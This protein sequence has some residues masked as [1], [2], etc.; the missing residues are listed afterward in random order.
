MAKDLLVKPNEN[1]TLTAGQFQALAEVPAESEWF[2]SIA[3]PN[4]KRAYRADIGDFMQ[5]LGIQDASMLRLVKRAHVLAWRKTFDDRQLEPATVRRKIAAVSS[6]FNFLCDANAV[7]GNPADGVKRPNVGANE[8]KSPALADEQ[9]KQLLEAPSRS[10]VKGL[11]D[12]AI[13]S[14]LLFHGLRRA[15]LCALRVGDLQMRKGVMHFEV[16]GKGGKIRFVPVHP[17]SLSA[18]S[19]YVEISGAPRDLDSPMFRSVHGRRSGQQ[20]LTGHAV[21]KNIVKFYASQ[22]GYD[23]RSVCVHGLRATAATNALDHEADI[24]KVQEW[25]GHASIATTR[26]YDRRRMKPEESP[27]FKVNY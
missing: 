17:H 5:F 13:L 10:T 6:L 22:L 3:N 9:A 8:G 4:T 21:Y 14:I 26:L 1:R 15:E 11:R 18:I 20:G 25:L 7:D 16:R 12:R 23:P 27:T 2:A 19:A 24:A